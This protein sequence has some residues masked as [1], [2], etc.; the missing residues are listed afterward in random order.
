VAQYKQFIERLVN[1]QVAISDMK[2][3]GN[4]SYYIAI[5]VALLR[6]G[7]TRVLTDIIGNNT[8]K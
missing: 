6:F 5:P 1:I 7:P 2:V 8:R 3:I 4:L